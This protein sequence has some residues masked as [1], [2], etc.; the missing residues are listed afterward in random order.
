[1]TGWER[2]GPWL[3]PDHNGL[4]DR[5]KRPPAF[6]VGFNRKLNQCTGDQQRQS[7]LM[8]QALCILAITQRGNSRSEIPGRAAL[9]GKR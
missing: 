9:K 1:M 2:P 3:F 6:E 8:Q 7:H 5:D 4:N